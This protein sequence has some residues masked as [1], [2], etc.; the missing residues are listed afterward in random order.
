MSATAGE[1]GPPSKTGYSLI[2]YKPGSDIGTMA[3]IPSNYKDDNAY[4]ADFF[5][6][7]LAGVPIML[8]DDVAGFS[9]GLSQLETDKSDVGTFSIT[10]HGSPGTFSI[11]STKVNNENYSSA[12]SPLGDKL[13]HNFLVILACNTGRNKRGADLTESM[14]KQLGACV[15]TSQ[16]LIAGGY[17]YD[18]S[19]NM[20]K[21]L[22][23]KDAITANRFTKS[24]AGGQKAK[25][26][27]NLSMNQNDKSPTYSRS[28]TN[29][30]KLVKAHLIIIQELLK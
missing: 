15:I 28:D 5:A 13:K 12:L 8:V 4:F 2:N 19:E 3:I 18:G 26:I 22:N 10:S 1:G 14:S 25:T 20:L 16:H 6:A 30:D 17:P 11:G 24:N 29:K 23:P 9:N 7:N 21:S 27:F